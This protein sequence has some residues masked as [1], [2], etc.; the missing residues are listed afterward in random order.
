M[1]LFKVR[2][3]VIT[4]DQINPLLPELSQRQEQGNTRSEQINTVGL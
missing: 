1:L 2:V 4:S 3:R